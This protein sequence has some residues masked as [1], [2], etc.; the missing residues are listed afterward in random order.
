MI[1]VRSAKVSDLEN[2]LETHSVSA[3]TTYRDFLSPETLEATFTPEK[4][5]S[6]WMMSFA[7][8]KAN[9]HDRRLLVAEDS[10]R[11]ELGILGVAR[12]HVITNA[13]ERAWVDGVMGHHRTRGTL[14]EIQT[15]YVHPAYQSHGVGRALIAEMAQFLSARGN[16]KSIVITLDG[17]EASANF[18]QRVGGARLVG[19]FEQNT[20]AAAG[21]A[22]SKAAA[23]RFNLWLFDN[24]S[25]CVSPQKVVRWNA[26]AV[27][28]IEN[29]RLNERIE[30]AL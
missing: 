17:Y 12:C 22:D 24:I 25:A 19:Q 5:R 3:M 4:L 6:N 18:Y 20:A 28:A 9:P 1:I 16:R 23:S 29:K 13:E 21:A 2:I 27:A 14:S 11:P 30:R 15:L 8:G 10:E 26:R 7:A